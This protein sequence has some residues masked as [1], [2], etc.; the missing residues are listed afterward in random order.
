[1]PR[2]AR[3]KSDSGCY[4]IVMR[5][6]NRQVLFKDDQDY[7]QFLIIL[8][9]C[10]ENLGLEVL[11]WCL[12]NNH[13][14]LL[15]KEGDENIS[16]TMKRIGVSYVRYHHAKHDCVG[17][18]FQDRF[19]SETIEDDPYLLTVVRY[20][21]QNPVKA[22]LV[23]LPSDWK[24][25]SCSG[26]YGREVY[27]SNLLDPGL[28]LNIIYP[29]DQKKAQQMFK[30]FNEAL[31]EDR[32]LDYREKQFCT[33][34]EIRK[35]IYRLFPEIGQK[36]FTSLP[37]EMQKKI[38]KKVISIDGVTQSRT[39]HIVGVSQSYISKMRK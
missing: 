35:M 14:H 11:G 32:C 10:K 16:A 27:P 28:I 20:I 37:K 22:K 9:R 5:G 7:R 29:G 13:V 18:L 36:E 17:H 12:M 8:N 30:A 15:L 31:N 24:W 39:A 4:H 6:I 38:I 26:Y 25:S 2:T 34:E 19:H 3:N 1:M 33:D 21:H 23:H